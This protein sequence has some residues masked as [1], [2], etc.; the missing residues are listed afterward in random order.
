MCYMRACLK[1]NEKERKEDGEIERK[2]EKKE[3]GES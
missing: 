3:K 1:N 2:K